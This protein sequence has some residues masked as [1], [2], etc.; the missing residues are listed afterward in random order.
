[1]VQGSEGGREGNREGGRENGT[2]ERKQRGNLREMAR[3]EWVAIGEREEAGVIREAA[4]NLGYDEVVARE[5]MWSDVADELNEDDMKGIREASKVRMNK[6]RCQML[7]AHGGKRRM[8]KIFGGKE[9][10]MEFMLRLVK[11]EIGTVDQ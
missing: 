8:V 3:R 10:Q 11:D 6:A 5:C 1:M 9:K 2:P 7:V 4:S